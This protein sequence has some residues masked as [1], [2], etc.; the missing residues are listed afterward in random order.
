MLGTGEATPWLLGS[1]WAL[2]DKDME[3]CCFRSGEV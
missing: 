3:L 1:V 2:D